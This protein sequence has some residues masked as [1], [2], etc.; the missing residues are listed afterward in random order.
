M[1]FYGKLTSSLAALAIIGAGAA[2]A[3]GEC[4]DVLAHAN[5]LVNDAAAYFIIKEYD[6]KVA[7]FRE[8]DEEPAAVYSTPVTQIN[9]ADAR[10]LHDGIRLRGM[11]EVSRLLEDLD[12]E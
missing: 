6:G 4:S 5:E 9:P 8:G 11:S 3:A 12:V 10:L 7:L 2:Y 1:N